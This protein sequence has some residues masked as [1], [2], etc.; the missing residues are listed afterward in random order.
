M[1][2]P[3]TSSSPAVFFIAHW[4]LGTRYPKPRKQACDGESC[5][6]MGGGEQPGAVQVMGNELARS[7]DENIEEEINRDGQDG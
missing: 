1:C 7:S 2:F 3:S 4:G 6:G 5:N